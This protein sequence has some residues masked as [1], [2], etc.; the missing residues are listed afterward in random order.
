MSQFESAG[1][2]KCLLYPLVR[3]EAEM[4][5]RDRTH[6]PSAEGLRE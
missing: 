4:G 5:N 2:D 1:S 6:E 3:G